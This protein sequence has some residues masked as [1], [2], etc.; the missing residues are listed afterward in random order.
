MAEPIG[1]L[2]RLESTDSNALDA[3][4]A[5]GAGAD[6]LEH[7]DAEFYEDLLSKCKESLRTPLMA[8]RA[9]LQKDDPTDELI[10]VHIDI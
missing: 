7:G 8:R 9:P 10:D 6:F 2:A 5:S 4:N 1:R 3:S